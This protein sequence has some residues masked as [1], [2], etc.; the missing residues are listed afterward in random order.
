MIVA[1]GEDVDGNRVRRWKEFKYPLDNERV[2]SWCGLSNLF[3]HHV[4]TMNQC[5]EYGLD[6]AAFPHKVDD[7]MLHQLYD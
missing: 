1:V 3:Y 2:T 5:K 4:T 6:F 7:S